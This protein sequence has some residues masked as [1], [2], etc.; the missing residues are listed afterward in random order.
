MPNNLVTFFLSFVFL[1]VFVAQ[2]NSQGPTIPKDFVLV[3]N[4]QDFGTTKSI[5]QHGVTWT[6]A[7]PVQYGQ[8]VNGDYWV[9]DPG[10][11]VQIVSISPGHT[12]HPD[13]G[14]DMNGSMLNPSSA[15]QGYDEAGYYYK[16]S[17]NVGIGVSAN[18][19]LILSSDV[20]LVSTI[21]NLTPYGKDHIS[22]VKVAAV[23]TCLSSVPL[24]G[25]FRP[26]ISSISKILHKSSQINYHLLKNLS[27]PTTKP[28]I[29]TYAEYF[30]MT[31]LTHSGSWTGR[32]MHPSDGVPANY[33]YPEYFS[34]AALM[35]HLDYTNEEKKPL[36]I[37]YIQLG[38]DIY[39]YLERGA[40]GWPPD[41]GH[42][43]ARK[44]P[45]L[46][47]GIMLDYFPM[48]NIGQ[49]SGE[50]LYA[51]GHGPG[52]L[53]PDYKHFG[54]DGQTFYVKQSDV[55]ITTS[56]SWS[57]DTRSAPNY[58]YTSAMIGMPEW[59][60]RYSIEPHR[61]D[62]SWKAKYRNIGSGARTWAGTV[63][64]ARIMDAKKLWNN[65]A[66]FD[67]VDRYMAIAQGDPDPF[68]YIVPGEQAGGSP[69]EFIGKIWD[70]YRALY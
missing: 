57:P 2:A 23:L 47:A 7:K 48:K 65:N 24:E 59:G 9:V 44:W 36:L 1:N 22:Y 46:F 69:G 68:N 42:S 40:N 6:F 67:Y 13:T 66:H 11:G 49:I 25:S 3:T 15:T 18:T 54:E 4:S 33:Y 29:A 70:A 58:P 14:R 35:L 50:Y 16:D 39:S 41:G 56:P 60:I 61:S 17:L 34:T 5:Q 51:D 10:D 64:A 43:S 52:N 26:G 32:E 38:I 63:L 53:P 55:D 27:S 37:N 20:S 30:K 12:V 28:K 8:F 31:W 21:S 45:I 62:A 19:P